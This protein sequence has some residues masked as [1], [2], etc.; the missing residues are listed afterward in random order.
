[1]FSTQSDNCTPFVHIFDIIFLFAAELEEPNW[2]VVLGFNAILTDK[3]I[4]WRSVTHLYVFPGFLTP[5]LTQLFFPK[6]TGTSLTCF[7]GGERRK[8]VGKKV[9]L[10]Q[11]SNSQPLGQESDTL[12]TELPGGGG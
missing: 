6:P 7:W 12:T 2:L 10:N 8:Y 3:V 9:H 1:M 5:V 4:S 11:G